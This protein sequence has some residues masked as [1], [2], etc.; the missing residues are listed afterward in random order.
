MED[1][2][3]FLPTQDNLVLMGPRTQF[4]FVLCSISVTQQ[5][6]YLWPGTGD[7]LWVMREEDRG[8][9]YYGESSKSVLS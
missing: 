7:L 3:S 4:I 8:G 1:Q 2:V 6:A 9:Q 5:E